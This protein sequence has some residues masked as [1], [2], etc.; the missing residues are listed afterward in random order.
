ML[1]S[2]TLKESLLKKKM[3]L[4]FYVFL[5]SLYFSFMNT[6]VK[7]N[8][9]NIKRDKKRVI[10]GG[11]F[12]KRFADNSK[13]LFLYLS[14]NL[15]KYELKEVCYATRNAS[16]YASLKRQGFNTV[17]IGTI[18]SKIKHM[19]CGVHIIDNNYTDID[20]YYS[21][22]VKRIDLWHGFP[23]KKVG[24]FDR[25][26]N[27]DLNLNETISK[28]KKLIKPGNWQDRYILSLSKWHEQIHMVSFGY[29]KSKSII[30][31]YPRLYYMY[32]EHNK[33]YLQ[34]EL[35]YAELIIKLKNEKKKIVFYL[36]TYRLIEQDND[37]LIE[38]ANNLLDYMISNDIYLF[39]KLH[40]GAIRQ[41]KLKKDKHIIELPNEADVY[42]FLNQADLLITDYSSVSFDFLFLFK[43]IIYYCF[44]KDKYEKQAGFSIDYDKNTPG[45]KVYTFSKLVECVDYSLNCTDKY[46]KT[47]QNAI[48]EEIDKVYDG[49]IPSE[50]NMELLVEKILR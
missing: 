1:L 2:S 9:K 16:I 43:P 35:P 18:E 7:M 25:N 15:Q 48:T 29:E 49:I 41:A 31:M 50:K 39:V 34:S 14:K 28:G 6:L 33:F 11:W 5:R 21:F 32:E 8:C 27:N 37:K 24:L 45:E 42:N 17:M 30:G 44:D 20:S 36:P 19:S 12:G 40:N 22:N 26:E 10:I 23:I 46:I 3:I 47:Y 38:T 13:A 4:N